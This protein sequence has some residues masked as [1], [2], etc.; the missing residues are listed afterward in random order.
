M[1]IHLALDEP[2]RWK[3]GDADALARTAIVHVTPGLDGVSRAVNEAERGLLPAEATIVA[4]QP[5]ARR[6]VARA[7]GQV[8]PLDPAAGASGRAASRAMPRASSTSATAAGRRTLRE[9]YADRIV[10]RLGES[11]E[12][13]GAATLKRV[14]ALARRPRGAEPE[15]RRRRHL[16]AARCA[17]DQ[18]LLWRPL[19]AAPGHRTRGRGPLARRREHASR[20]GARR[21]LGLPRRQG[22]DEA[23]ARGGASL[24]SFQD[25]REA[26]PLRDLDGERVFAE[27]V[28]AY[29]AAGFDAIGIWEMK[30]P[31]DDAANRALLASTASASRTASRPCPRSSSSGSRAWRGR[32]P[33]ASAS[34]RSARRSSGSPP[35][36]PSACSSSPARLASCPPRARARSSSTG[37]T[38]SPRR[39]RAKPA[40]A[41]L[42]ADPSRRSATTSA[43][44]NS[45][46][47]ALALLDEAGLDDVGIMADT[48][49]LCARAARRRSPPIAPSRHRAPRRRRAVPSRTAPTACSPARAERARRSSST[50]SARAGWD[51]TLDVEIFSTPDA[52][53]SLP[54]DEA[55]RRAHAAAATLAR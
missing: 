30:L 41:R 17:L 19:A 35:T 11:I 36:S 8:D 16:R 32:R 43:F 1:Q 5:C 47:D 27:D 42:R 31:D 24:Q 14:V 18:N 3:G 6:P 26:L 50:R 38:P 34:R 28:E 37:C 53:W 13:L 48:Y 20:P 7:R 29:A 22:A 12:N 4:G 51:G 44:V 54:V 52:F 45:I 23:A 40:S 2:P 46:A 9:A 10:A 15:P 21:R 55:A 25:A 49:N 39:S 33:R